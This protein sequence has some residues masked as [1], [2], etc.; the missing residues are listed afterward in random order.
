MWILTRRGIL[1]KICKGGDIFW[2]KIFSKILQK[3]FGSIC[4]FPYFPV[5]LQHRN[6]PWN[7]NFL[8]R[9][10][11]SRFSPIPTVRSPIARIT[12]NFFYKKFFLLIP[13][14]PIINLSRRVVRCL[15]LLCAYSEFSYPDCGHKKMD[16]TIF[17]FVISISAVWGEFSTDTWFR[18]Y[19]SFSHAHYC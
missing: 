15:S 16:T 11:F 2:L 4:S 12:E 6:Y 7:L 14:T 9:M 13:S 1:V 10:F 19:I 8:N 3:K 5:S 17:N 18:G